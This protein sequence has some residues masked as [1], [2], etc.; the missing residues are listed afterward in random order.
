M[1]HAMKQASFLLR[2]TSLLLLAAAPAAFAAS[3]PAKATGPALGQLDFP[4]TGSPECQRLFRQGMLEMHSFQYDQAHASF[5]A[6]LK[7]DAGCAMA[8][9]GDAMAYTHPVWAERDLAKA[10]AALA[11]IVPERENALTPRERAHIAVAR[12]LYESADAK[13]GLS[14]WLAAVARMR[15]EY[16]D[17]DEVALQHA[18][19]LIAVHGYDKT[20][21]REQSEAG[22]LALDVLSRR[23]DHPG[24]AHYIIHAFDNP[25]HAIL[26]LPAARTYARIAPAAAHAV[27]MPSHTFVHLG[28]WRDV[29]PSNVR[30]YASSQDAARA[31][32]QSPDK[33]DWHSYSWLVAAHLELGQPGRAR[34]LVDDARALLATDDSAELRFGYADIARNYLAQTGRWAEAE[35]LAAPLLAPIRGEGT[36]AGGPPACAEH[37]PGGSGEERPPFVHIARI[38]AHTMRAEAA[39]RTGDAAAAEA[40]A[41]D[42]AAV[43]E[44]MKPWAKTGR[45]SRSATISTAYAGEIRARAGLLRARTPET[46][47][48]ALDA[49]AQSVQ[50]TDPIPISGPAFS[51]TARERL[52][53]ALLTAGKPAEALAEYERVV[54]ARPNRALSLLGAARAARASGD[55]AKERAHYRAL[56]DLWTDA[57]ADL[58]VLAEVRAGAGGERRAAVP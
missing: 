42:I 48:Q 2:A 45:M 55:T 12:A 46:E 39:L 41:N 38:G 24:A 31:L 13:A 23:P 43:V 14:A 8:A 7:A 6:A 4:V 30:A 5:G 15:T 19:A 51:L 57:D 20:R 56:A 34:K 1:L 54:E 17:D 27:H 29:V 11:R 40:R 25:E 35:A 44:Q 3:G 18:L 16:P 26:A 50:L 33:W 52:A 37:A 21:Q 10:K 36:G 49:I 47:K 32:G 22:A 28:M 9:W 58:P 53:E